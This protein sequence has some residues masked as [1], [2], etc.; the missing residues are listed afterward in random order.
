M[1]FLVREGW[2]G[3]NPYV[4]LCSLVLGSSLAWFALARWRV[5]A[6]YQCAIAVGFCGG[7]A[8]A[9]VVMVLSAILLS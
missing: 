5:A 4:G 2:V 8:G 9:G 7:I 3:F 6:P 1:R